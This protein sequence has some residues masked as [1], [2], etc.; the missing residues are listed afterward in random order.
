MNLSDGSKA[1]SFADCEAD[2]LSTSGLSSN[3]AE[4][5]TPEILE[6][7]KNGET[8]VSDIVAALLD[9]LGFSITPVDARLVLRVSA[10]LAD[11]FY[12][13]SGS[14]GEVSGEVSL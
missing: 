4:F 12:R 9:Y 1:F 11:S 3:F 13:Q 10:K 14:N 5:F 6:Q 7:I 8:S 2:L